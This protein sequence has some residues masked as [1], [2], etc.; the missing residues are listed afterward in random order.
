MSTMLLGL[1][2]AAI[3]L[4]LMRYPFSLTAF[5]GITSLCGIVVRNGIILIDYLEE[6][7][8]LHGMGVREAAL[9]AGKRR[10]RPIFLTSMAA[11]VG[12]IPMIMSRSLLWGPLGTVICFGLLI[13]MILT[14]FILP[15]LYTYI[16][17][18]RN[19][20]VARKK[21]APYT[22]L[23]KKTVPA[24]AI[25][26]AV[27]SILPAE[28]R[29][30]NRILS[31][32][33]CK[34][35]AT[36]NNKK[37]KDA[38]FEVKS[39][40]ETKKNTFTN[41]FPKVS[42]MG[43]AMRSSDYLIK[44]STP[45]MNLPV[46]DGNPAS[47]ATATQFAYVPSISINALDYFNVASISVS[48]PVFVGGRIVNGN[49]LAKLGYEV[50]QEKKQMSTTDVL[51]KTENMYWN[52]VALQ[53]KLSTLISYEK[54]LHQLLSDVNVSVKAGLIQRS[55]LL[56]VQLKLNE[57]E[58]N[59]MKLT[60]GISLSKMALC[61]H[62][63]IAYDSTL[64]LVQ[65]V[66]SGEFPQQYITENGNSVKNR[67]EYQL[68]NKALEAEKLQKKMTLG[69]Y[70]PQVAISA[71]GYTNDYM[72]KTSSNALALVTVSV[73]ISDWWG[74][75]HKLK[76]SQF[77]IEQ[78]NN[79]LNETSELLTLQIQQARNELNETCFQIKTAQMSIDQAK[80]NMKV[81]TDNYK[82]GVS[83]MSDLLEA[84]AMY[85]DAQNQYTDAVCTNKIKIA[86][87]SQAT[88]NYK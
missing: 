72:N 49:K 37:I 45:A 7:R 79:K 14:L 77:K 54:L 66:A 24:I 57:L 13:S 12:V 32:D 60:N 55:D 11:S 50:S 27:G 9:A 75:S 83:T 74:G 67:Y 51:V 25:F 4:F 56:K 68:L 33:S 44:G 36:Q 65:P 29:A 78:A 47:L 10:M 20:K 26:V 38:D 80:E 18:D 43:L 59:K 31:I 22:N 34:I 41:Y 71:I 8:E 61:Q 3:G 76:E 2:G 63:G 48:Q 15:V 23:I 17:K 73:P 52:T 62:I 35:L 84:Q 1:P 16:Y 86:S 21:Q 82:A 53:E 6:L 42:A 69:E 5:I 30:Q 19:N 70:L 40:L 87:Y 81:I 64:V 88:G 46:Y 58:V 28:S 85:Q 39:A